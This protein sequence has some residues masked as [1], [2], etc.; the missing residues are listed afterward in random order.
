M[1]L[2]VD[3]L[4]LDGLCLVQFDAGSKHLQINQMASIYASG[5]DANNGLH[6]IEGVTKS[7][8]LSIYGDQGVSDSLKLYS[9][10]RYSR[11]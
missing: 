4:W 3:I 8:M 5:W 1:L 10:V 6:G 9:T 7:R 2:G 11:W